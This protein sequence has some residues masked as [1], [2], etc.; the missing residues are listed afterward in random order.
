MCLSLHCLNLSVWYIQPMSTI[1]QSIFFLENTTVVLFSFLYFLLSFH[2]H[3]YIQHSYWK[4]RRVHVWLS[5]W[6]LS[7]LFGSTTFKKAIVLHLWKIIKSAVADLWVQECIMSL[8][9]TILNLQVFFDLFYIE[10]KGG[11]EMSVKQ[12]Y[13]DWKKIKNI[14][15]VGQSTQ[16]RY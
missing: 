1:F 9:G 13:N 12:Q 7:P 15:N 2:R 16:I 6:Y 8:S 3:V 14:F 5:L 11:V 4:E 10:I